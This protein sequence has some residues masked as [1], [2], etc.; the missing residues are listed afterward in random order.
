MIAT[1]GTIG[2]VAHGAVDWPLAAGGWRLAAGGWRLAQ[3]T[4]PR[5]LGYTLAVV[6]LLLAPYLALRS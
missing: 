1:V 3:S 5:A 2:Y 6:L 4:S